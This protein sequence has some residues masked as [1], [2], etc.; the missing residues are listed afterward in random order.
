MPSLTTSITNMIKLSE[1]FYLEEFECP[2]CN[3]VMISPI[4]F[5]KLVF[6]RERF[7]KPIIIDSGYRC[8]LHNIE[9]G[10]AINSRH[11]KGMAF[12]IAPAMPDDYDELLEI[13]QTKDYRLR[14]IAHP[15]KNYMHIENID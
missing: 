9:I 10:G 1:H 4:L 8:R 14:V 2:C 11:M 15:K 13:C 12:D 6:I 7:N 3:R 5:A